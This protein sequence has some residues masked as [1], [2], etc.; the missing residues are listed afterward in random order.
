MLVVAERADDHGLLARVEGQRGVVVLQ[1]H[2]RL[3]G[4]GAGGRAVGRGEEAG[5]VDGLGLVDVG[6]VEEAGAELDPQDPADR[7]VEPAHGDPV[8]RQQLGAVVT[9]VGA[10][11]LR[12]GAG[13]QRVG[14]RLGAVGRGAVAAGPLVRLDRRAGAGLGDGGVVALDE[15]VEAPLVLEDVGLG[16]GVRAPRDAVD[17]VERAHHRVRACVDRGLERRE[18]EVAQRRLGHV[19]GVVVAAAL[20]LAV[21]DEVLDA[22]DDL[23]L[24]RVVRALGSLDPGRRHHGADVRVLA[25]ALDDPAPAGL[26]GDVDHR[27]VDLLEADGRGLAGTDR[28]VGLGDRRVERAGGAQR[29]GEDGPVAVDGVVGEQDRDVQPGLLDGDVLELVDPR[30]VHQAEHAADAVL[31]VL[32]R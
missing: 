22:G 1:Q 14:P 31:G 4:R 18:V 19:R 27:A 5:R 11:H 9:D 24:L 25:V 6:V 32:R 21:A 13:H 12:V 7:V 8:L 29:D 28:R 2:H 16:V 17:R 26:V 23:V 15:A 10:D 3:A 30:R 20:G